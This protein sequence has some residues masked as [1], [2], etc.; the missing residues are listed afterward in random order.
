MPMTPP[1]GFTIPPAPEPTKQFGQNVRSRAD[2][3]ISLACAR[4]WARG[5]EL[6][7]ADGRTATKLLSRC[8]GLA[9]ICVDLWAP[10]PMAEIETYEAWDHEAHERTARARL[11]AFQ[12]RCKIV[13][14]STL[15]AAD[16]VEDGSLDFVFI[17]ADH[18]EAGV[19]ADI[20]A[21]R[22][23]VQAGGMVLGHDISW[24]GVRAAVEGAFGD[25]YWIAV[26]AC[27]GAEV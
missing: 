22:P 16:D 21:W 15:D 19:R 13:K 5:A 7:I 11:G 20:A 9:L 10:Q 25:G 6:G 1:E 4:S 14:A 23:K 8:P 17:D 2:V 3:L 26:D 24:P 12:S 27:W 18:S